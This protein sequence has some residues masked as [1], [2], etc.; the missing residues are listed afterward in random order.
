MEYCKR[1]NVS[2]SIPSLRLDSFSFEI[3]REIQTYK[4]SG[5]TFAPEAGSQRLRDVINK[6]ITEEEIMAAVREAVTLGWNHIKFYFM[7]GLPTETQEDIDA[8]VSVVRRA[9]QTARSLQ[10][11][12]GRSFTLSVSASNFVP[13]PH[14]PFQWAAQDSRD[15]LYEKNMYL[16]A[17]LGKLKGV[18]F[19]FHDTRGSHIE[20]L[21]ARGDRRML[22]VIERAA[23]LGCAFD[24]WHEHFNYE[25][26]MQA[27]TDAGVSA[28]SA[29][30]TF[31]DALPW[32]HIS[33]GIHK[34]YLIS[35][36]E[37]ALCG[38]V[39][40]DCR[41]GCTGCGLNCRKD[42]SAGEYY[43]RAGGPN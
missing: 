31:K 6:T 2:L 40:R 9:L 12:G 41:E 37:R 42:D 25:L 7:V 36:W 8:I 43:M 39:T 35:E 11:K 32:E 1:K 5:L 34:A 13:K 22:S 17:N 15:S 3:L 14:T 4:K 27:F 16:K 19:K 28:E 20:A 26:W 23:K 10:K 24:S 21:L 29:A 18:S 33:S 38:Y 30:F